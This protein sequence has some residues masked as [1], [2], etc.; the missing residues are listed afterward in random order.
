VGTIRDRLIYFLLANFGGKANLGFYNLASRIINMPNSLVSSA[1]RPVFFQHAASSDFKLLENPVN[2][3]LRAIAICVV[4]F[5]ILFLFHAQTL[6]ALFFG[7]PWRG[8]ALFAMIIS[9]PAIP[10]LLGNWLDRAFDALGRQRLA[11]TME[12]SFS[13]LSI[14]VLLL[15]IYLS[16]SA[17][18][19]IGG[20][21]GVLAIYYIFWLAALFHIAGYQRSGLLKLGAIV[22]AIGSAAALICW[23]SSIL[24]PAMLAIIINFLVFL[25]FVGFY[26]LRQWQKWKRN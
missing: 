23:L 26:L 13:L 12:L 21:A 9:V 3:A 10:L 15:V 14:G 4:P 18:F 20:Q 25:M 24:L 22:V 1:V 19:A 17:I 11:F 8:A 6:F 2:Q 7:E 16:R 5:W